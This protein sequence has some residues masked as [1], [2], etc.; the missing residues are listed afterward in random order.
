M[1]GVSSREYKSIFSLFAAFQI[2]AFLLI[3]KEK[4]NVNVKLRATKHLMN[5]IAIDYNLRYFFSFSSYFLSS[6]FTI[7]LKRGSSRRLS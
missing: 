5:Y 1:T 7:S 4:L 2:E 3:P 6:L